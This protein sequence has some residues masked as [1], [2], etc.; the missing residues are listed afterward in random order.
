MLTGIEIISSD[1]VGL[2]FLALAPMQENHGFWG[3]KCCSEC[4]LPPFPLPL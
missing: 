3:E 2:H 1:T 4:H